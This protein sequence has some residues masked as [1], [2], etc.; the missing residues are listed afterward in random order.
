MIAASSAP[1]MRSAVHGGSPPSDRWMPRA[2]GRFISAAISFFALAF[3]DRG[4]NRRRGAV[5]NFQQEI[6]EAA[7]DPL[8]GKQLVAKDIGGVESGERAAFVLPVPLRSER[9]DMGIE[10][11]PTERLGQPAFRQRLENAARLAEQLIHAFERRGLHAVDI[12]KTLR[13]DP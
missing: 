9:P 1:L 8:Q 6:V 10:D 5:A 12:G 3:L 11:M 13:G 7:Q 2:T 4:G